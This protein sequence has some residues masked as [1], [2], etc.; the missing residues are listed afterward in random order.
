VSTVLGIDWARPRWVGVVLQ[1]GAPARVLVDSD[2]AALVHH[3]PEAACIG[4]DMPIGT[5][6]D[7][8]RAS[9]LQAR[10]FVGA[11]RSSVFLTPP[12]EVLAVGSYAEANALARATIG[13]GISQQAWGLRRLIAI[14]AAVAEGDA[15]LFEVHPEV[16]F[17]A[18]AGAPMPAAKTT[19]NGQ[20]ARRTA[21]ARAGIVLPD[22]LGVAGAV[23]VAD[24]LDAAVVAWSARRHAAGEA[25]SFPEGAPAGARETIWY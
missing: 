5:P 15:R 12:S 2:L 3:V 1:D 22:D 16:S 21:L 8:V 24:V 25:R 17:T 23:P 14:V 18:L 11:R 19:W 20:M 6:R 10:T 9:E 4:V 7:G 13:Q